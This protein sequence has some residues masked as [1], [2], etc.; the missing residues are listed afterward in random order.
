[1]SEVR[2]LT[3]RIAEQPQ[4]AQPIVNTSAVNP[5][6]LRMFQHDPAQQQQQPQDLTVMARSGRLDRQ[7]QVNAAVAFL[8][9]NNGNRR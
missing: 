1:V 5:D 9:G 8:T 2:D 4:Q 3:K 6:V 7:Q